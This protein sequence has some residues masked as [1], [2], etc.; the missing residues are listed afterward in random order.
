[1]NTLARIL[2]L[3]DDVIDAE[4]VREKLDTALLNYA[5]LRVQSKEDF[6][7]ALSGRGPNPA[8]RVTF[9]GRLL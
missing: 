5:I 7:R 3:E 8:M 4:L 9:D 2:H 1:M 6:N